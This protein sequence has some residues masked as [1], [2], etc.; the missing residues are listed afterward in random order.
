MDAAEEEEEGEQVLEEGEEGAMVRGGKEGGERGEEV[1]EEG[2]REGSRGGRGGG[3]G[4][5]GFEAQGDG[6][7][8]DDGEAGRATK[9]A[10]VGRV[11]LWVMEKEERGA[12]EDDQQAGGRGTARNQAPC[13]NKP[14]ACLSY[15]LL[16]RIACVSA[17]TPG[18]PRQ[19]FVHPTLMTPSSD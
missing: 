17:C 14:H 18:W 8:D 12:G 19:R 15:T 9:P 3:G 4:E 2:G 1:G 6:S 11:S 13:H 16:L 10:V 7:E 5:E